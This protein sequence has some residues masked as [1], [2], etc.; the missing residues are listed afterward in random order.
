MTITR[1]RLVDGLAAVALAPV[2]LLAGGVAFHERGPAPAVSGP[3]QS[4]PA[5]TV[6]LS[7][8]DLTSHIAALQSRLDRLP[9]DWTAWASLGS[10]YVAQA[11]ATANPTFYVKAA[12]AFA[13]SLEVRDDD[14]ADALVGQAALANARHDFAL[15]RDLATKAIALDAYDSTAYG[16]LSDSL[17]QMGEYDAAKQRSQQMLD[18]KPGVASFS[19][20]SYIAELKGDSDGAR[21]AM[22]Q[23]F[24]VAVQ[25]ADRAFTAYYL[26][27]LAFDDGDLDEAERQFAA[28]LRISPSFAELS[29]GRARVLAANGQVEEAVAAWG[30]L[31]KRLPRAS[32]LVEYGDYLASLERHDEAAAQYAV[33]DAAGK[34]A[35]D[36]GVISDVEVTLYDADQGRPELALVN[37]EAQS[38][39][40]RSVQVEDA[41]AWALH[42]A[43]RDEEAL[44]HAL[45]AR[46]L[47]TRSALFAYHRG[48]I[49]KSLGLD[50]DARVSLTEALDINP[51]FS[52]RH[53]PIADQALAEL[54]HGT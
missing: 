28:G 5:G 23:A 45:A 50:D 26:G 19:R 33:A 18:L 35:R 41:Y 16:V 10:A 4:V 11:G 47:G 12:Q 1:R 6:G 40:R 42:A 31:V 43:G 3:V 39:S 48:M 15:G 32:Y 7:S 51:Y 25:P 24:D 9:G 36:A 44:E 46:Q 22:Q 8:V 29:A 49:Q 34:L 17:L 53:A 30:A 2:L 27:Q 13:R 52:P 38:A 14:N 54:G 37:A 20:T 21:I